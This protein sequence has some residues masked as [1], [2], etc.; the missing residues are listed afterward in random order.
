M[1]RRISLP[2]GFFAD[3]ERAAFANHL[4][5]VASNAVCLRFQ[6]LFSARWEACKHDAIAARQSIAVN[7]VPL[8]RNLCADRWSNRRH[9]AKMTGREKM[10]GIF[11]RQ[12]LTAL[13]RP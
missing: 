5:R 8:Y 12:W 10:L 6:M 2:R 1:I 13:R 4:A 7:V 9:N 11:V 3:T